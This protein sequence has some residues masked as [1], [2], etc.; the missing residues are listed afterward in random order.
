MITIRDK[1]TKIQ[2]HEE[3]LQYYPDMFTGEI[4]DKVCTEKTK[5]CFESLSLGIALLTKKNYNQKKT[6]YGS[7]C[8]IITEKCK[9]YFS[10]KSSDFTLNC[11]NGSLLIVG[12]K[13]RKDW[14]YSIPESKC[15]ILYE[16]GFL[17]SIL[18]DCNKR[19]EFGNEIKKCLTKLKN[20]KSLNNCVQKNNFSELKLLGKGSYANVFKTSYCSRN[21]ALKISKIK[22]ECLKNPYNT[23]F[24]SWH[25]IYY[26]KNIFKPMIEK[27]IC[28]NLPLIYDSFICNDCDL[29]I[30]NNIIESPCVIIALELAKGN[31]KNILDKKLPIKYLKSILFQIMASLHCIQYR[32]QIMNFDIKKENVLIYELVKIEKSYWKYIIKGKEYYVPNYGYL[33]VLNDFGISRTMSP[34]HLLYKTVDEK[35]FRLGSRYAVL[36]DNLFVP[37]NVE[38]NDENI[39]SK[40]INWENGEKTRGVEFKLE[41]DSGHIIK[42]VID[43][44]ENIK[45]FL[46]S[47][48]IPSDPN[49]INFFKY[50]EIIPPFEFYNDTQDVIRMFIGGKRT[51]Q[52][53]YHRVPNIPIKFKNS[54]EPYL[55]HTE[56]LKDNYFSNDPSQVLASYFIESYFADYT[57]IPQDA[58]IITTYTI[59]I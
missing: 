26:L 42:T 27:N 46:S 50:P 15:I 1:K 58:K 48:G 22:V 38:S 23:S 59:S 10:K 11:L 19:I 36:K 12:Y 14:S 21:F 45:D 57:K 17:P 33:A 16:Q 39:K 40:I 43:L 5:N 2:K 56:S 25:E 35:T 31:L 54:L 51:T 7:V 13:F 24:S 55:G 20:N 9:I 44:P 28:P 37:F 6:D 53:G 29:D 34:Y 30:D 3:K 4:I 41:R 52:K 18:S 8:Y 47:K 32:A 49:N